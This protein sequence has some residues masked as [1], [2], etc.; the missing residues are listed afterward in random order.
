MTLD[1]QLRSATQ[2]STYDVFQPF[3]APWSLL[4]GIFKRLFLFAGK[5]VTLL[6]PIYS[7]FSVA[8]I[9]REKKT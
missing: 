8:E 9:F 6:Q 5:S 3:E 1:E 7:G 4:Q 2:H